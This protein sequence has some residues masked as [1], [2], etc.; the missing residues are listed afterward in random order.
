[1]SPAE[2]HTLREQPLP[3]EDARQE[4]SQQ[5]PGM[6]LHQLPTLLLLTCPALQVDVRAVATE[7]NTTALQP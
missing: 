3:K 7:E 6:L 2:S 4:G 5:G 1:M